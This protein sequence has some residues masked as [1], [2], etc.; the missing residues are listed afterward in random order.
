MWHQ[1]GSN[2]GRVFTAIVDDFNRSQ[3]DVHVKLVDQS[4]DVSGLPK[5][6][7]GLTTGDVPDVIQLEETALQTMIDSKATVP[8]QACIDADHYSLSDFL[9]KVVG[10]YTVQGVLRSMPYNPSNP[11]LFYNRKAFERAGL[12]PNRPPQTLAEVRAD[13]EKIVATGAAKYG[14]S[15]RIAE[16]FSEF[17]SS[18]N[19]PGVREQ[20]QRSLE[21]R[22]GGADRQPRPCVRSGPGGT[23]WCVT[24]WR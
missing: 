19:E 10:Y 7:A 12:D 8:V 17:W 20:R 13:S 22:D 4:A 15:L 11:I 21:A 18:K 1:M 3:H 9:P 2:N 5:F 23:T 6:R 14:I 24:V 16:F